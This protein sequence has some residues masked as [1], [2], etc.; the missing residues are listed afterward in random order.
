MTNTPVRALHISP[1]AFEAWLAAHPAVARP[2]L[3]Q[4]AQRVRTTNDQLAELGL[5]G[6][7]ARIAR[8][9]WQRFSDLSGGRPRSGVRLPVNQRELASE[10]G[11]TRESVNKHLARWKARGLVSVEKGEILLL[12][13]DAFYQ[14]TGPAIA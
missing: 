7:E 5:L 10:I 6:I 9:L 8:R 3:A 1:A 4:L 13:P 2:M 11:V 12:E 14:E